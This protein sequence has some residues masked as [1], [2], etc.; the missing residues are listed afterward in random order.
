M[1]RSSPRPGHPAL[2]VAWTASASLAV[3]LRV[4]NATKGPLFYGYDAWGHISYVFFLDMYRSLPWADQGWSYFHPPLHY[5]VGWLFMQLGDPDALV[6]ALSLFGGAMSLGVAALAA[7]VV[8]RRYAGST[9]YALLAFTAVAFLPVHVYTSPM[10]GNEM[11]AAF[12]AAAAF[13]A[14]LRNEHRDTPTLRGDVLTGVLCGLAML[15]KFTDLIPVLAIG[16][17]TLVRWLRA[18][19]ARPGVPVL[20]RRALAVGVPLLL[21][22]G[23][24]YARNVTA[25]GTPFVTSAEVP[26]VHRIQAAQPPGER[27]W[28]DYFRVPLALL[29]ESEPSSAH[30]LRAVWP[31]VYTNAWMDT[32]RES[33]LPFPRDLFPHPFIHQLTL[34][35]ATLGLVPTGVALFGAVLAAAGAWR[36]PR[37]TVDLGMWILAAGTLSAFVLFSIQIPTWA[38]LKASYLFNL[39]LPFAWFLARGTEAL[40]RRDSWLG[41]FVALWMALVALAVAYTF[42][43]GKPPGLMRRDFDSMQMHSVRAHFGDYESTRQIFRADAPKRGYVE[44]RAAAELLDGR[45][46]LARRFYERAGQMPVED[47]HQRP[48]W[49]NRLAV[50]NLLAGNPE[51]ALLHLR[52]AV[53]SA[54]EPL[55]ELLVN[56]AVLHA[57]E[58][59]LDDAEADLRDALRLAPALPPAW[60]NLAAVLDRREAG[61]EAAEARSRFAETAAMPPRGFPYGVGNG[62]L[63]H[64]GAGQRF[65]LLLGDEEG[66]GGTLDI[67]RPPRARNRRG[68][69]R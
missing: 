29:D 43:A 67:W 50:A 64:S 6:V 52:E 40:W 51:G 44:A 7:A 54:V 38:A 56:R 12:L 23:P 30:M 14:H 16:A 20:A 65:M 4:W 24:W 33:Q 25:F 42:A 21:V 57:R 10:P 32:F 69:P 13:A 37:S 41:G 45:P 62:F 53:N 63:Y 48:W 61:A 1:S 58:G 59:R 35:F 39:S 26:D 17:L 68:L 3:A 36:D 28:G 9:G 22:A 19:P 8:H 18:G 2:L 49:L 34:V 66:D 60:A 47:P 15:S 55:P 46:A 31:T 11:T 27:Q 5:L